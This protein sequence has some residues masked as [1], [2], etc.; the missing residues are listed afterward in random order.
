MDITRNTA[1]PTEEAKDLMDGF[2]KSAFNLW[3]EGFKHGYAMCLK[4]NAT[5]DKEM[6]DMID[7]A[8]SDGKK[9]GYE[10]A[11]K[12]YEVKKE[13]AEKKK[14]EETDDVKDLI[15]TIMVSLFG[16]DDV[17]DEEED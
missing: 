11:R 7:R 8:Y 2:K 1:I 4:D 16:L 6:A 9:A 10:K 15:Y 12:E 14:K 13:S 5:A 17:F 3:E